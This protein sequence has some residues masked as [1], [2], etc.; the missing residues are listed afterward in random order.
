MKSVLVANSFVT[1][2]TVATLGKGELMLVD[3]KGA[4]L[5]A[6]PTTGMV[7]FIL[8]LGDG[9]VKRGVWINAANFEAATD[10]Y[11]AKGTFSYVLSDLKLAPALMYNGTDAEIVFH[12]KPLNS[13][14]GYPL[15]TYVASTT[16]ESEDDTIDTV[17]AR[18]QTEVNAVVKRIN[19]RFGAGSISAVTLAKASTTIESA[20]A[21][22][23]FR[24]TLDGILKG[25]ITP[26][27]P[28]L[29]V[30]T[31][32]QVAA[33]EREAAVAA[34][35]FNPNYERYEKMY[36][37]IFLAEKGKTYTMFAVTSKADFT[38][39]FK[40]HTDGMIVTQHIAIVTPGGL[41]ALLG[42]GEDQSADEGEGQGAAE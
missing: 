40:M 25:T 6:M 35:G 30:G 36:G 42:L 10:S 31:Y 11:N 4:V 16:I 28:D 41:T 38:H 18:L 12:V 15:E 3:S 29:A 34:H 24:V 17:L 13:F 8:G 7:Q 1:N 14:G 2:K 39:P 37:D 23:E 33:A 26:T 20:N 5:E 9:K 27:I 21:G 22:F 32:E 19:T